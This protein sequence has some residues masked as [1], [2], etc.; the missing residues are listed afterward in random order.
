MRR[1]KE[2]SVFLTLLFVWDLILLLLFTCAQCR[3]VKAI[4]F[5]DAVFGK[6]VTISL[7]M[8]DDTKKSIRATKRWIAEMEC[9]G[10]ISQTVKVHILDPMGNLGNPYRVEKYTIGNDVSRDQ[11]EESKDRETG[12][13]FAMISMKHGV[14]QSF[15]L[16]R[17]IWFEVKQSMGH[18]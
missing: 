1:L 16:P 17:A 14:R 10:K 4:G 3:N 13:L 11:Y 6:K 9:L 7:P 5:W 15:F 18:V 2:T 8:T 12:E